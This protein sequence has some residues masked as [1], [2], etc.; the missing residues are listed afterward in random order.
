MVSIQTLTLATAVALGTASSLS[1]QDQEQLIRSREQKLAAR[2]LEKADWITDYDQAR[3]EAA[4]TGKLI[5]AYFG[6]SYAP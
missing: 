6:R 2:F 1:C 5:F 3:A 4:K